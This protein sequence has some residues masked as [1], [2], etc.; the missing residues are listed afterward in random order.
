MLFKDFTIDGYHVV[1]I[2]YGKALWHHEGKRGL[3]LFE[4]DKWALVD[5]QFVGY[6]IEGQFTK[7]KLISCDSVWQIAFDNIEAG[8]RPEWSNRTCTCGAHSMYGED[9]EHHTPTCWLNETIYR[10][11]YTPKNNDNRGLCFKCGQI[12]KQVAGWTTMHCLCINPN[13]SW[14]ER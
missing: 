6:N 11:P 14:Y 8:A 10:G 9:W 2:W 3:A 13:C 1:A 4:N 12:T 7:E 5:Q